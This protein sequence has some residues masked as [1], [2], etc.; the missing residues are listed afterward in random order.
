MHTPYAKARF[1]TTNVTQL[2]LHPCLQLQYNYCFIGKSACCPLLNLTSPMVLLT[3]WSMA[4]A[5]SAR[6]TPPRNFMFRTRGWCLSHQLSA[7]S[8]ASRVQWIRD[9]WPAPIPITC[10]TEKREN[11]REKLAA[12]PDSSLL[13]LPACSYLA[14][15]SIADGVGL[16]VLD[17]DG[18]HSEVTHS[19]LGQLVDTETIIY[20]YSGKVCANNE[21]IIPGNKAG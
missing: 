9:C 19:F 15:F 18:G 13:L 5:I 12:H 8:P 11:I 20:K 7:L 1:E 17:C 6:F 14:V 3:Y 4:L 16:S 21:I 2:P 10:R